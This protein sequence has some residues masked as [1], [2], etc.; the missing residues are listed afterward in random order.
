M[1]EKPNPAIEFVKGRNEAA[2]YNETVKSRSFFKLTQIIVISDSNIYIFKKNG[3]VK[4]ILSLFD[5]V[6]MKTEDQILTLIYPQNEYPFILNENSQLSPNIISVI[7]HM[8][9][10]KEQ[11]NLQISNFQ[12]IRQK[13]NGIGALF[14]INAIYQ[15]P[16]IE[17]LK[18]LQNILRFSQPYVSITNFVEPAN[19]LP[20]FIKVLPLCTHI[21]SLAFPRLPDIDAYSYLAQLCQNEIN[22][23][24]IAV[25]GEITSSFNNFVS[26]IKENRESKLFGLS[27][28]ESEL[29]ENNLNQLQSIILSS[30]IHSIEFHRAID[31][32]AMIY[33]YSTF[34]SPQLFENLYSLNLAGTTNI[35]VSQLFP[36]IKKIRMLCLSN[37]GL[38]I[39]DVLKEL[40]TF[41]N[42][43]VLDISRNRCIAPIDQSLILPPT[44]NT[45]RIDDTSFSADCIVPFLS[46]IFQRFEHGLKLSISSLA[47]ANENEWSDVFS[48]FHHC[49][50][51]SLVSLVWDGNPIHPKFFTFLLRSPFLTSLSLNYCISSSS[52]YEAIMSISLFIQSSRSISRLSLRGNQKRYIGNNLEMLLKYAQSSESLQFIDLTYSK[53]GDAGVLQ[54]SQFLDNW[55]PLK[56]LVIDGTKP[57]NPVPYLNLLRNAARIKNRLKLSYPNNDLQHLFQKGS[58]TENEMAEIRELFQIEENSTSFF[59][60]PFR[61]YRHYLYDSFPNFLSKSQIDSL[62]SPRPLIETLPPIPQVEIPNPYSPTDLQS[63]QGKR[64]PFVQEQIVQEEYTDEIIESDGKKT[65]VKT[66]VVT[67][68]FIGHSPKDNRKQTRQNNKVQSP[69]NRNNQKIVSPKENPRNVPKKASPKAHRRPQPEIE[70]YSFDSH[71]V[72][73][74]SPIVNRPKQQ[75]VEQKPKHPSSSRPRSIPKEVKKEISDEDIIEDVK[76]PKQPRKR[77]QTPN[78]TK[79]SRNRQE[80]TYTEDTYDNTIPSPQSSP[81]RSVKSP[82][83]R[84][85]PAQK[86][87]RVEIIKETIQS[88][89]EVIIKRK[90]TKASS[91]RR[92]PQSTKPTARNAFDL[93][94]ESPKNVPQKKKPVKTITKKSSTV[95][96][97]PASTTTKKPAQGAK[98]PTRTAKKPAPKK[99]KTPK[100][101]TEDADDIILDSIEDEDQL[102]NTAYKKKKGKQPLRNPPSNRSI[103]TPPDSPPPMTLS[104]TSSPKLNKRKK[105]LDPFDDFDNDQKQPK[106]TTIDLPI[107]E[108]EYSHPKW[109]FP[110]LNEKKNQED[111]WKNVRN[112]YVVNQLVQV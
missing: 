66:S 35:I 99:T 80:P 26:A 100:T 41:T 44:L 96:E 43:K 110:T 39:N 95:S 4:N 65:E 90:S 40:S 106:K 56:E 59:M 75:K 82:K 108:F 48:F 52:A 10:M 91:N 105:K 24:H 42:I 98:K 32:N 31:N 18:L 88:E 12:V 20:Y 111:Y 94:E 97:R 62:L 93:D 8:M 45:L 16:R 72:Q 13:H 46:F 104:P 5:M 63:P 51:R 73:P 84:Q 102:I 17:N 29:K 27:F 53:C 83:D 60:Q 57:K 71:D 92:P 3:K 61:I 74:L 47:L 25:Q 9:T 109:K 7:Q 81:K 34:L 101:P 21:K 55:T 86:P 54:I 1:D 78:Q 103:P 107:S 49:Q 58:I 37:C 67:E 14:K 89:E 70:E 2:I 79:S 6:G 38:D 28:V 23:K 77:P 87:K 33:F 69:H 22:L 85:P 30:G 36:R 15:N 64:G 68:L 19:F 76:S 50:F 112:K 11:S